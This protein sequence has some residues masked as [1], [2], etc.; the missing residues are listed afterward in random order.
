MIRTLPPFVVHTGIAAPFIQPDVE[1]E[2]IA[3]V[4]PGLEDLHAVH[5]DPGAV[6]LETHSHADPPTGQHAFHGFRYRSDGS[7]NPDFILNQEPYRNASILLAGR[8]FGLGSLQAFAVIRLRQCGMRVVIAPSFGP[9]FHDD[10]FDFN[11]LPVT[12]EQKVVDRIVG[13]VRSNPKLEMTVDL[14]KQSV[15]RADMVPIPFQI[16][17]RRRLS[18]L[19]GLDTTLDERLQHAD[20]AAAI[21]NQDRRARPWLYNPRRNNPRR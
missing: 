20:S 7:E 3:P 11:L 9:V 6:V 1:G 5:M 10:C 8:N 2:F 19:Q 13:K 4:G 21:R 16:D 12:L 18:L 15:F 14:E 17:S